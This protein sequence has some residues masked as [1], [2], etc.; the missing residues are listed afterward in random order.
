MEDI[1]TKSS[2]SN[3]KETL[4]IVRM[5]MEPLNQRIKCRA[6]FLNG[7]IYVVTHVQKDFQPKPQSQ[8]QMELPDR[9]EWTRVHIQ[10]GGH[11]YPYNTYYEHLTKGGCWSL[12]LLDVLIYLA[13]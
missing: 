11:P 5:A 1:Q 13:L 9:E 2:T 10:E 4:R 6:I 12:V 3:Q 8:H 7:P